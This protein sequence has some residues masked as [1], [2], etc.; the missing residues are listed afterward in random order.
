MVRGA[1]FEH[2]FDYLMRA[3]PQR[4]CS[5]CNLHAEFGQSRSKRN[6]RAKAASESRSL[7]GQVMT[8]GG[9]RSKWDDSRRW[10]APMPCNEDAPMGCSHIRRNASAPARRRRSGAFLA[11][12]STLPDRSMFT[13]VKA[14]VATYGNVTCRLKRRARQHGFGSIIRGVDL[15]RFQPRSFCQ[16]DDARA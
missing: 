1:A 3:R 13:T 12:R 9:S 2:R 5:P 16:D 8:V 6:L 4:C 10:A 14:H 15:V 11:T 7:S